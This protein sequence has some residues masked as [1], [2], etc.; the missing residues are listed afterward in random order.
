M[1]KPKS[2]EH[3][4][5]IGLGNKGKIVCEESRALIK[6]KRQHQIMKPISDETRAKMK[7]SRKLQVMKPVSDE[8]RLKISKS[9][10][11]HKEN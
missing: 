6:R 2:E 1:N 11:R 4:L 8:T 9:N 5:L 3:K 10:K 7:A